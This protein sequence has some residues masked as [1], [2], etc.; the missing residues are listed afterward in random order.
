[1]LSIF[2]I[3]NIIFSN[4]KADAGRGITNSRSAIQRLLNQLQYEYSVSRKLF[5]GRPSPLKIAFW[6]FRSEEEVTLVC[7][8]HCSL[9]YLKKTRISESKEVPKFS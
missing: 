8:V 7:P 9:F 1:M 4:N 6:L 2:A 5:S 3:E